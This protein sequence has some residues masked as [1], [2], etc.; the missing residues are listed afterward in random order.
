MGGY[1]LRYENGQ[2]MPGTYQR[3]PQWRVVPPGQEP[4]AQQAQ[5]PPQSAPPQP[6]PQQ[7]PLPTDVGRRLR[8]YWSNYGTWYRGVLTK[9]EA[10]HDDGVDEGD[11]LVLY[12][13]GEQHWEP[14]GSRT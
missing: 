12:D 8:V 2:R 11:F 5:L 10:G 13:D 1:V 3:K 14:L 4:P 6:A 9:I 7:A